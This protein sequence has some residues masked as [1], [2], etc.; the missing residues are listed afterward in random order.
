MHPPARPM[1]RIV[2]AYLGAVRRGVS[3]ARNDAIDDVESL[4]RRIHL[5]GEEIDASATGYVARVASIDPRRFV[6]ASVVSFWRE[7]NLSLIRTVEDDALRAVQDLYSANPL[8]VTAAQ[9]QEVVEVSE[10]R[11]KF[12]ARDQALKLNSAI[13]IERA[14]DV[15]IFEYE[16]DARDDELTRPMHA[17]LDGETF[18]L[19]DPPVTNEQG[20]HNHPGGDY[21]CRCTMRFRVNY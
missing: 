10:A 19:S 7:T 3:Q 4:R 11:A 13:E 21:Q 1:A 18:Q 12:W 9:I 2:R 17:A 15:G 5:V 14:L 6:Q 20:D 8:G 16:W